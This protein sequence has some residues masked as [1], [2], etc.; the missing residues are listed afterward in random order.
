[1]SHLRDIKD[2]GEQIDELFYRVETSIQRDITSLQGRAR[3][4]KIDYLLGRMR[5][6]QHL[7]ESYQI[8]L[9]L[10]SPLEA[11]PFNVA[12]RGY[13]EKHT[14]LDSRLNELRQ[15][16]QSEEQV[17]ASGAPVGMTNRQI[18][19]AAETIQ[20]ES[21]ASTGRS[22]AI[23]DETIKV[24]SDTTKTLH[25]QT[26][27][28][29]RIHQGIEQVDSNA[30]TAEKQLRILI[31]RLATDRLVLVLIVLVVLAIIA[32]IVVGVVKKKGK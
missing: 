31:R 3:V 23:I 4:E 1:M 7:L 22:L 21:K 17:D 12:Y 11:H 6:A 26:D 30:R 9:S 29:E 10:L 2:Y 15:I 32:A 20:L 27:Q 28:I 14:S 19:Q 13:E 24:A 25:E 5:R 16:F 18:I 8:E